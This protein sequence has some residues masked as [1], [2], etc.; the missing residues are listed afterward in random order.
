[1]KLAL[2]GLYPRLLALPRA[3]RSAAPVVLLGAIAVASSLSGGS[4]DGSPELRAFM[5]N[6]GHQALYGALAVALALAA[7]LRLPAPAAAAAVIALTAAVG[8]LDEI[9][10]ASVPMRYSSLWDLVSD[11]LGA[12]LALTF[13]GWTARRDGPVLQPGPLLFCAGLSAAWN[14]VP[15]FA[16]NLPLTALLP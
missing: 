2:R 11:T 15:S 7:G 16:P 10:Q 12:V 1:M 13:A 3:L 4:N 9:H 14:C 5:L 6:W 8:L